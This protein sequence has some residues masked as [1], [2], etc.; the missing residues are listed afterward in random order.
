LSC[1]RKKIALDE[2]KVRACRLPTLAPLTFQLNVA[3]HQTD[4]RDPRGLFILVHILF[5]IGADACG[6]GRK[7]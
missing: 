6:E 2:R 5:I 3:A 4:A 1:R 7:Q